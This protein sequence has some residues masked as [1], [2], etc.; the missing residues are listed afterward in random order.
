MVKPDD[1]LALM[2]EIAGYPGAIRFS[3]DENT[4]ET[5]SLAQICQTC[6]YNKQSITP[7]ECRSQLVLFRHFLNELTAALKYNILKNTSVAFR[8]RTE[9]ANLLKKNVELIQPA[10]VV[11]QVNCLPT[12]TGLALAGGAYELHG[13]S[14]HRFADKSTPAKP[15]PIFIFVVTIGSAIDKQIADLNRTD[16]DLYQAFL[17]NGL[18]AALVETATSDLQ[19]H[20]EKLSPWLPPGQTLHRVSPGFR[21][22]PLTDQKVIFE[23]LKPS[24]SIG[25]T[26]TG[27]CLMQPLKSTSGIMGVIENAL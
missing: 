15:K 7:D 26:L 8:M 17:L 22:W 6:Q 1:L 10:A 3:T 11:R 13:K 24:E 5:N 4:D 27:D 9:L 21:D 2:N 19:K 14:L 25:V 23:I 16:G 12:E 18:A 20:L